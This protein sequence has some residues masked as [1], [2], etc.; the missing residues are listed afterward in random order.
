MSTRIPKYRLHKASGQALVQI[1]GK[2]T[3]LGVYGSEESREKYRRLIAEFFASDSSVP[4][5][6]PRVASE[7]SVNE[8]ILAYWRFAEGYYV[9]DGKPTSELSGMRDALRLLKDL[10]GHSSANGFGPKSLKP[11]RQPDPRS[12]RSTASTCQRRLH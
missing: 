9:S 11:V 7:I 5:V 3:Y 8:L 1:R 2:R 6:P 10:F 12:V 4:P